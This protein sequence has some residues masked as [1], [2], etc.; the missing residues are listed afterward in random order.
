MIVMIKESIFIV[1]PLL[2]ENKRL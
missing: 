2:D 1:Y